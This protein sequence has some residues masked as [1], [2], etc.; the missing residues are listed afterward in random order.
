MKLVTNEM[1]SN[2]QWL[3]RFGLNWSV[4]KRPL[5]TTDATGQNAIK[6]QQQALVRTDTE[7]V[8]NVVTKRYEPIQNSAFADLLMAGEQ[9]GLLRNLQGGG[10]SGGGK[11]WVQAEFG[12]A[13]AVGGQDEVKSR[14]LVATSHDGSFSF[15]STLSPIRVVCMNTLMAAINCP[16]RISFKHT[17]SVTQRLSDLQI[18]LSKLQ[19][20]FSKTLD[21]YNH[22]AKVQMNATSLDAYFKTIIGAK[23]G[24]E[25]TEQQNDRMSTLI[26]LFESGIGQDM[27]RGTLW[28]AFNAVTEYTSHKLGSAEKR[29]ESVL[30]GKGQELNQAAM[31]AAIKL[32]A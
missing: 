14:L 29:E 31:R 17:Q 32:V 22:F 10:F 16:S 13:G 21:L 27:N 20:D 25:L 3:E 7:Q 30:F 9:Q 28:S 1:M 11:I 2:A 15:R 24:E 18:A 4:E 26:R 19:F 5:Y 6:L 12:N 8:L 23:E